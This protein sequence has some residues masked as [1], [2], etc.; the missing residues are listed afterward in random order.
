MN[1]VSPINIEGA[2]DNATK[3]FNILQETTSVHAAI[4]VGRRQKRTRNSLGQSP[5]RWGKANTSRQY[6]GWAKKVKVTGTQVLRI[7]NTMKPPLK[8]S[9]AQTRQKA[10]VKQGR[11]T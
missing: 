6:F 3:V 7:D 4:V 9:L 2:N 11:K 8:P 5:T 10:G 1:T